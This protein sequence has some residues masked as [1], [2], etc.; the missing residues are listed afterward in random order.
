MDADLKSDMVK[1]LAAI[2]VPIGLVLIGVAAEP[3]PLPKVPT[4]FGVSD[5]NVVCPPAVFIFTNLTGKI[6]LETSTN[7]SNWTRIL[8]WPTNEY[9]KLV[10]EV[11]QPTN[12]AFYWRLVP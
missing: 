7:M 1:L 5:T 11:D 2:S 12:K 10:L 6:G 3:P 8:T 9:R 4:L